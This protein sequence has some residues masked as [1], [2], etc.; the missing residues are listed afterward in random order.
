MQVLVVLALVAAASARPQFFPFNTPYVPVKP[1]DSTVLP[2]AQTY[3]AA[4]PSA[5]N[6]YATFPNTYGAFPNTYGAFPNTYGAFP[7]AYAAGSFIPQYVS[8]VVTATNFKA[9]EAKRTKRSADPEAQQVLP[10]TTAFHYANN[11]AVIPNVFPSTFSNFQTF[12][13]SA[14]TFPNYYNPSATR[15][16]FP[17]G[18]ANPSF[19]N[20]YTFAYPNVIAVKKDD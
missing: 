11:P 6:N 12:Q 2:V 19:I 9:V 13:P 17:A 15:Y 16:N 14:Y 3:T 4:Y 20:P 7:S 1:A 10:T 8:P 5:F 18:V